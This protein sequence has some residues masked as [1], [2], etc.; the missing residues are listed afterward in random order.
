M[1]RAP[2]LIYHIVPTS[3]CI[4]WSTCE[5]LFLAKVKTCDK[6]K[7]RG[8]GGFYLIWACSFNIMI[9]LMQA[10]NDEALIKFGVLLGLIK[11]WVRL[12]YG[13]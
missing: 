8:W 1:G 3:P 13:S 7:I 2:F 4:T 11:W 10:N 6:N 9:H 5:I 12:S